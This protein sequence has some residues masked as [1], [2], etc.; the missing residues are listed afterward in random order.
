[1]FQLKYFL[2]LGL[3]LGS[4]GW[5]TAQQK[6]TI[7][8]YVKDSTNGEALIGATVFIPEIAS[9][10]ATNVYGFYSLSLPAGTYTLKV[11]YIGYQSQSLRVDLK[12]NTVQDVELAQESEIIKEIVITS[13]AEDANIESLEMSTNKLDIQT[14]KKIPALLGEVDII[15]SIQLLPGVTTVGEGATGF[16]VR[17]GGV[18]QN[19]VLLDEAPVYNSSHLFGFFSIF[20]PDAVKDVKLIKGGIP[21]QYGG[22]VSSILDVR[23][24]E[25]NTKRFSASGGVG[26]IF[27]RLTLEAPIVKDKA[28]F[29]IAGRRSYLDVLAKPFLDEDL[30]NSVFNFYDLTIK[31]NYRVNEKN[32][33]FVSGY[34]GRDNFSADDIFDA[35][36]GNATATVRWNTVINDRVFANITAFYS[37]YDY[38][39]GFE[40][41]PEDRF[42]WNSR[43]LNYSVKPEFS[44]FPNPNNNI[45][46]GGQAILYK[47]KPAEA[48]GRSAGQV[49]DISLDD[50][51]ALESAVYI[52]NEQIISPSISLSYGLRFSHYRYLGPGQAY[53][54]ETNEEDPAA[55]KDTI[56]SQ[57]FGRAETIQTYNNFEPRIA[58][59]VKLN[60]TTSLKA[61]YNRMAQYI[62]LISNTVA[63]SPL[64]VWTP[65][66]NNVQPQ[67]ADQY[68][69]GVF[70]NFFDNDLET[71]VEV[72]YR[73]F[74]NIIDYVDN[75]DLLINELLE[76]DLLNGIGRAYGVELYLNKKAGKFN[77]WLSYTLS[78][79]ERKVDGLNE[80]G[81]WFLNRY[82]QTHILNLVGFYEPNSR[83]SFSG[84]FVYRTGT[85][86]TFPTNRF[87][88]QGIN[89]IG[90][91]ATSS[92]NNIR[93]TPYWRLD[94]SATLQGKKTKRNGKVRKN[95]DYWVFSVYNLFGRRNAYSIQYQADDDGVEDTSNITKAVRLSIV[96]SIIPSI[97]YNFKF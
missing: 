16:N 35:S 28:S 75:A 30:Q 51:Y 10:V 34:L 22:R 62:H 70:K 42:D 29:I 31:G 88:F 33:L 89:S 82:D 66:T 54:F 44:F 61:S 91:N 77:G 55:R 97:S 24:K 40:D 86:G 12:S 38:S 17:G 93:I 43:I 69:L 81:K 45:T 32:Q 65:S 20:N 27:S 74:D 92:R 19:L 23:M 15:K 5:S 64:D 96:G 56:S 37:N 83:W 21:A 6:V 90:D 50:Q 63:A 1:M 47:F 2:A 3:F 52:G 41:N 46:L 53:T 78:K 9:G 84:N 58:L 80:G 73:D 68:T 60:N 67:L 8:G 26:L 48:V 11:S 71:S 4:L 39:L 94:L 85:P 36:W 14:I 7:N 95:K 18:G 25:G 76:G 79:S 87:S 59:K 72:F 13:E 49:S 57:F